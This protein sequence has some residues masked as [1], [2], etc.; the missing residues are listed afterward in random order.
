MFF[1]IV[2]LIIILSD[3]ALKFLVKTY[4]PFSKSIPVWGSYIKLTYV[5]NSGAA[6]SLFTG[7][8]TYLVIIGIAVA[9]LVIY[10]HRRLPQKNHLLQ[11]ALAAILGGSMGNIIDRIFFH[12]VIDYIDLSFWPI[13]NLSLSQKGV[14]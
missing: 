2:T 3:Q 9:G 10:F 12:A 5:K 1:Y 6:F 4:L 7:Y 13:F 8:S 11:F 14:R